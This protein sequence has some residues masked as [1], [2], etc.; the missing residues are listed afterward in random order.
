MGTRRLAASLLIALGVAGCAGEGP[1]TSAIVNDPEAIVVSRDLQ[2]AFVVIEVD[3]PTAEMVSHYVRSD[4]RPG[5]FGNTR[6][7]QLAIGVG[8]TVAVTIVSTSETGYLDFASSSVAPIS[9]TELPPQ[10]VNA[11]GSLNVPPLGRVSAAGM[12]LAEFE[13]DLTRRLGEVLVEPAVIVQL[14][15]RKSARVTVVGQVAAPGTVS[16]NDTDARLVDMIAAVGGPTARPEDLLVRLSRQGRS[17]S[18][19][20]SDLFDNPGLNVYALPGDILT[21]Q[22]PDRKLVVLGAGRSN[23]TIRFDEPTV[24][25]ADALAQAGGLVPRRADKRGVFLYRNA[26]PKLVRAAGAEIPAGAGHTVP[27]IFRFDLSKPTSLFAAGAFEIDDGDILYVA[28]SLN[29]EIDAV[30]AAISPFVPTIDEY[31]RDATLD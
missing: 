11:G 21:I 12:T 13:A 4:R 19:T 1:R 20:M 2:D 15:D 31:V 26:D 22:P 14:L 24:S 3:R 23:R 18:V 17:A 10:V 30:I 7:G 25:L 16:I 9:T 5:F 27:T 8:D 6:A 29:E 28:N